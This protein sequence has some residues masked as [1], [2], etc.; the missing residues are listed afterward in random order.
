[1]VHAGFSMKASVAPS[2]KL[3][4]HT[5]SLKMA[6]S[7]MFFSNSDSIL[8]SFEGRLSLPSLSIGQALKVCILLSCL[9]WIHLERPFWFLG[10]HHHR[11]L[12]LVCL[13]YSTNQWVEN[14]ATVQGGCLLPGTCTGNQT[15]YFLPPPKSGSHL[16]VDFRT[17]LD[18]VPCWTLMFLFFGSWDKWKWTW[19]F[20]C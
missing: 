12:W 3:N 8:Q 11:L 19:L 2:N 7:L 9:L 13:C 10:G 17:G 18:Y 20:W 15:L 5:I 4:S 16:W 1:M 14:P 6:H